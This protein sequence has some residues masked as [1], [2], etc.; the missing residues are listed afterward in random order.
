M[1][2]DVVSPV[3]QLFSAVLLHEDEFVF[4]GQKKLKKISFISASSSKTGMLFKK[5]G[6]GGSHAAVMCLRVQVAVQPRR[7]AT[8]SAL[9]PPAAAALNAF[10]AEG[11]LFPGALV[12]PVVP[13][14]CCGDAGGGAIS[15]LMCAKIA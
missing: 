3:L 5:R 6:G 8:V 1:H 12:L 13:H 11:F 15:C 4:G 9:P 10:S 14:R 2:P 7:G